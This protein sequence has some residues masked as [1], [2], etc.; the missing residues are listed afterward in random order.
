MTR[1][2]VMGVTDDRHHCECC[3]RQGLKRVV[4]IR[5]IETDE[6]RHFG[7][8]CATSPSKAFGVNEQ[9]KRA[10]REF[11]NSQAVR[12]RLAHQAYRAAKGEYVQVSPGHWRTANRSLW[13][14]CYAAA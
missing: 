9:V 8:T 11:E 1:Y 14:A 12:S 5:D 6:V 13:E 7:T 3:G 4:W 2:E 10:V